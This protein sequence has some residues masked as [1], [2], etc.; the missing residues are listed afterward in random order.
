MQKIL[1]TFEHCNVSYEILE[2]GEGWNIVI[3]QHG[4]HVFG[5]F[6]QQYPE[7]VFWIPEAVKMPKEYQ[8]LIDGK[9]W[10]TGGD[11][12]WIGP[13][14]QFNIKDRTRFRETLDTP[15]TIDP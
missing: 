9:I 8:K 5:P 3:S 13:E 4:G 10:N 12:V 11:R 6:S 14:I 7:G 2:I 1:D 15:K